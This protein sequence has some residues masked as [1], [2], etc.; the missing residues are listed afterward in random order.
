MW[1]EVQLSKEKIRQEFREIRKG[2]S[3]ERRRGAAEA[4]R[5]EVLRLVPEGLVMSFWSLGDEIGTELLNEALGERLV[6][7]RV[8]DGGLEMRR[9]GDLVEGPYG[10]MEPSEGCE[11]VDEVGCVLVP[12]LA[13]DE[14]GH[15][16]GY[17][18]GYYDRCLAGVAERVV[19]YGV[20]FREQLVALVPAEAHDVPVHKVLSF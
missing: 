7:P 10:L 19:V 5:G 4:L 16:V 18:M 11:R 6:L 12:G 20:A 1:R 15:R 8:H 14:W 2:L 9:A 17:G 13:F 3:E